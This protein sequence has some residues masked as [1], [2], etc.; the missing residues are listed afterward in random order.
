MRREVRLAGFGGQGIILSGYIVGKAA[1]LYGGQ[2][3]VF[4]QSYGPEAR[5]GA[6]SAEVVLDDEPI[7]YPL[8][9]QPDCLVVLSHEAYTRYRSTLRPGGLLL[10]DTTVATQVAAQEAARGSAVF[11][12]IPA[13]ALAEQLGRRIVANIVVLGF[14]TAISRY[15]SRAAMEEA[16]RGSVPARTI[17]LNLAAYRAGYEFAGVQE[18]VA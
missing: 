11:H 7:D 9:T 3:A 2:H 15:V 6:C 14:W 1:T 12:G 8:V 16:V 13:T 17:E 10:A 18:A 4:T 5:G